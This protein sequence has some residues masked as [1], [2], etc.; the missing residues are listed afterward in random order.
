MG[1]VGGTPCI[2]L[3]TALPASDPEGS[4]CI[5]RDEGFPG[6]LSAEPQRGGLW[7]CM[8]VHADTRPLVTSVV[9]EQHK[10]IEGFIL[11]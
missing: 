2:S 11:S 3:S 6:G 7:L 9:R 4:R 10:K 8:C 1:V 5:L